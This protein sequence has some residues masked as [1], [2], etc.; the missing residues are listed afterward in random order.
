M[1][2]LVNAT[3]W[4]SIQRFGSLAISFVSNLVLARLLCPEDFGLVGMIM[5]FVGLADVLVDGGLGNALIQSKEVSDDDISTVFTTNLIISFFLFIIVFF[6]APSIAS[7]VNIDHFDYFLRIEAV[8]ILIRAFYVVHFSLANRKLE[9]KS[10]ATINLLSNLVATI[11]AITLA[12]LNCGV[13][14]LIFRNIAIDLTACVLYHVYQNVRVK[15]LINK[16]SFSRLFNYGVFVAITN[17]MESVYSNILSFVIGKKFSIKEL[18]YYNQAHSLEQIPVYSVTA[19]LNQVIFPFLSKVQGDQDRVRSDVRKSTMCMSFVMFP[20][21][22]FLIF[23]AKPLIIVLYSEK[24]L[25]AVP[26]FRILCLIGFVNAFYHLN[27]SVLKAVGKTKVLFYGQI[28]V[29]ITGLLLIFLVLPLGIKYVVGMVAFNSFLSYSLFAI[30]AGKQMN[31]GLLPQIS[32]TFINLVISAVSGIIVYLIS[33]LI[34]KWADIAVLVTMLPVYVGIYL[35]IHLLL[36]SKS[37]KLVL[38]IVK[39]QIK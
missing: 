13:W 8:M 38:S 35:L 31:Y 29:N 39:H 25:P 14:S 37:G 15:L 4:S 11:L 3:F 5:V 22:T 36:Q 34:Y 6:F 7:Y 28:I 9:F 33:S 16:D 2:S 1:P 24:W 32:D 17:M 23:F 18:G 30:L 26:Y 21:M 19:I 20:L 10:L 12:Y 27:R